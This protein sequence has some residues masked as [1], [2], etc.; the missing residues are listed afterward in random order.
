MVRRWLPDPPDVTPA[1]CDTAVGASSL[2][3]APAMTHRRGRESGQPT[4]P[5]AGRT[6]DRE[7]PAGRGLPTPQ[8]TQR[9]RQLD[10]YARQ[11][12]QIPQRAKSG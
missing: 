6:A 5:Q 8:A 4:R 3:T 2:W 10:S 11:D 9:D 12:R 7:C 1:H